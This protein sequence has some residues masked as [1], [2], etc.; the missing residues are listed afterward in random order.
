MD[1]DVVMLSDWADCVPDYYTPVIITSQQNVAEKPELVRSFMAATIRG[2]EFAIENPA[3][4]ADIL[5]KHAPE[6][7]PDLVRASQEWLSPHY[8][9]DAARWGEQ[10]QEIWQGYADWMDDRELLPRRI[11]AE[12]AFTNEFLP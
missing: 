11:D 9:A 6:S 2:Y 7:N 3:A 5:L 4:A 1:L 12:K 8:R 10:R